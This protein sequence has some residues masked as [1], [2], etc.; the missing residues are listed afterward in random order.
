MNEEYNYEKAKEELNKLSL[1]QEYS[2]TTKSGVNLTIEIQ[3]NSVSEEFARIKL[4]LLGENVAL[5]TVNGKYV[6]DI[7]VKKIKKEIEKL[8]N[9][10]V[11]TSNV[12]IQILE[13][14]YQSIEKIKANLLKPFQEKKEENKRI[15]EEK[16]AAMPKKLVLQYGF[17]WGDYSSED[18]RAIIEIRQEPSGTWEEEKRLYSCSKSNLFD[19]PL[20]A[21]IIKRPNFMQIGAYGCHEI[22]KEEAESMIAYCDAQKAEEEK[23]KQEKQEA[24]NRIE[25][26]SKEKRENEIEEARKEELFIFDAD[27]IYSSL[28]H[29]FLHSI[30]CKMS[31][32]KNRIAFYTTGYQR[33]IKNSRSTY[34]LRES[35]KA[36]GCEFD[37]TEKEWFMA[38]S[39]ENAEKAIQWLKANDTKELPHLLGMERCWECGTYQPRSQMTMDGPGYYCGC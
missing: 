12:M 30:G 26:E 32:T 39:V 6:L 28:S 23:Q 34:D 36:L 25:Q 3:V 14:D 24:N 19:S 27:Q 8:F 29:I 9:A 22:T 5:S 1:S 15:L 20:V 38:Y 2:L 18:I 37:A 10:K 35:L 21:Q 11:T 17:Y 13:N 33:N 7:S 31:K 16:R 4:F